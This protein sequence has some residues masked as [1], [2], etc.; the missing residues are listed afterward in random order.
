MTLIRLTLQKPET[1]TGSN[2]PFRLVKGFSLALSYKWRVI[3]RRAK[4]WNLFSNVQID[5]SRVS[6]S[7]CWGL[8][9]DG[10]VPGGVNDSRPLKVVWD[11]RNIRNIRK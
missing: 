11:L 8:T 1:T 3:H 10:L 2:G 4:I 7:F 5:I 9:C 6:T